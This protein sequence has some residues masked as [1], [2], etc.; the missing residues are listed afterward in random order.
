MAGAAIQPFSSVREA[1]NYYIKRGWQIVPLSS[2][3][4]APEST[5]WLRLIFKAEDFRPTDNIGIRS[6]NGLVDVDCDAPEVVNVA[7]A[8]LPPTGTIY[9][10]TSKP[11]SH[12]LYHSTFE[13]PVVYKDLGQTGDKA[14]L[15]EI[16]INHQSMAPPSKHP[17][18]E[19]VAWDGALREVATATPDDLQRAVRLAASTAL[20]IRYYNPPG[21][22]HDW[23][24]ALAGTL[25]RFG[26][27]EEEASLV[28]SEAA[29]VASDP[30]VKDRLASVR[31]TY[32]HGD[33]DPMRAQK[34][35]KEAMPERG[36]VFLK[37]LHKIWGSSS[38][39]FLIDEKSHKIIANGSPGRE[40]IKRA[41]E[42]L[43]VK[44]SFD[45]FSQKP[46]MKYTGFE[47]TMQDAQVTRLWFAIDE[48]YGFLPPL[49]FFTT[50]LQDMAWCNQVHPVRN[51]FKTL[52]WDRVAR[53][54]T[55]LAKYGGA[56]DTEYV[57]A[58]GA[59]VLIAAVRRVIKPG[60]KFD[61][62]MVLESDQGQLKSTALRSLCPNEDWFSDDLPLNV[63]AK[64]VIERTRGKWIIEAAELSGLRTSQVEHLKSMLSRQIDGP[65]RLAYA[66]LAVEQARQFV[67]VGTTNSH[68][69]LADMTGNRR[70]WPIRVKLFDINALNRDRDQL[71]AEAVTREALGE[72]I[73]LDPKLYGMAAM[74]QERRRHEHPWEGILD[75]AFPPGPL[76]VRVTP[77]AVWNRLGIPVERRAERNGR[78]LSLIMQRLGFRRVTV[79]DEDGHPQ[80]GW[81]RNGETAAGLF[82]QKDDE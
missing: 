35:L 21:D 38:S 9:G 76:D 72:S 27:T 42:K 39:A 11:K 52:Q 47:G 79:R 53:V 46:L 24:L 59:M 43:E 48:R 28:F 32:S 37:S 73:R 23:S 71:W 44:L 18:G 10:R 26:L 34:A 25:F 5:N 2:G 66:H 22:R 61:E 50:V 67:V 62:L 74:Q 1:A 29:R 20:I 33:D 55:W 58:V 81:G 31:S 63:D 36:V 4:K 17:S 40:N 41:I 30:E 56:A 70:F 8:F 54:D 80:K 16:R 7:P 75:K 68:Q 49:E 51:Y 19:V 65:V 77:D 13:K 82:E 14:T 3:T 78:E 12:W 6:V 69:Y 15:I 57:R 60:C 45:V 64:Q